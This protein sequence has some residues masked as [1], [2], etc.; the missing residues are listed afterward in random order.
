MGYK[1]V[2]FVI[3]TI[4]IAVSL[5]GCTGSDDG[6]SDNIGTNEGALDFSL[7]ILDSYFEGDREQFISYLN[8][9]VYSLDGLEGQGPYSKE[10]YAVAINNQEIFPHGTNYSDHTMEEYLDTYEPR[11]LNYEEYTTQYPKALDFNISGWIL[12][13]DDYMFQGSIVKP[14]KNKFLWD[15]YLYFIV[16]CQD[17]KWKLIGF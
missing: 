12:D 4:L 13:D 16:T 6:S 11:V 15:D 17:D 5:S 7:K 2:L 3:T 9:E 14:D 10:T 1:P 8:E